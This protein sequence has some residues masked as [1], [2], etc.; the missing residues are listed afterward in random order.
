MIYL[1]LSYKVYRHKSKLSKIK[2]SIKN[3][4]LASAI[5]GTTRFIT[6]HHQLRSK[7]YRRNQSRRDFFDKKKL[8]IGDKPKAN[9]SNGIFLL[10]VSVFFM[11][12]LRFCCTKLYFFNSFQVLTFVVLADQIS[13][14]SLVKKLSPDEIMNSTLCK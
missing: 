1:Y 11:M 7:K 9:A 13:W 14:H 2:S 10:F 12:Y 8:I 6:D 4:A 3:Y 5:Q